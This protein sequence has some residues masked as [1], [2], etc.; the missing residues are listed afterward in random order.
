CGKKAVLLN[1][2]AQRE[3][4]IVTSIPGTTRDIL[5]VSLDIGGLPVIVADTAGLRQTEDVV[6]NIGIERA[7]N[8]VQGS[9]ISLCGP[10]LRTD[11]GETYEGSL[12]DDPEQVL[13]LCKS[14]YAQQHH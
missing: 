8:R 5:E 11:G 9:D 1:F 12:S 4:A 14:I 3:A 7:R 6:E 2:L 13:S 10:A